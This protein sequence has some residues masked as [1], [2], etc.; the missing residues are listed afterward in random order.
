MTTRVRPALTGV[1]TMTAIEAR[2][3]RANRTPVRC[4][5]DDG[6]GRITATPGIGRVN[7]RVQLK[8]LTVRW[9]ETSTIY[10]ADEAPE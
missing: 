2:L 8:D 1:E 10:A 4:T 3:A 7:C 6:I 5:D 9:W